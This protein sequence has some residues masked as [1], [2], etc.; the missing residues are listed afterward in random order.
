MQYYQK[1]NTSLDVQAQSMSRYSRR[2]PTSLT[3]SLSLSVTQT[4]RTEHI[5]S[6]IF[7]GH[8]TL[9]QH[10]HRNGAYIHGLYCSWLY[11][12]EIAKWI[13][14]TV[15]NDNPAAYFYVATYGDVALL[16]DIFSKI[17]FLHQ[18]D[19][20]H[21]LLRSLEFRHYDIARILI[22]LITCTN[23]I[24]TAVMAF[25]TGE[26]LESIPKIKE[27]PVSNDNLLAGVCYTNISTLVSIT[28]LQ[29]HDFLSARIWNLIIY[30]DPDLSS[31][32]ARAWRDYMHS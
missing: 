28:K 8:V 17:E 22:P 30:E 31:E 32:I 13:A 5:H 3:E 6:A 1:L 11:A 21:T 27:F 14:R 19:L 10:L 26:L 20:Q 2:L 24:L 29:S 25:G 23:I 15:A 16:R 12:P 4:V 18:L 7:L 9:S